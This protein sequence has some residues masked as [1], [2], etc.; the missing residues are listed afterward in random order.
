MKKITTITFILLAQFFAC[1]W[2]FREDK[3]RP[4]NKP[5]AGDRVLADCEFY[6]NEESA[7]SGYLEETESD[8]SFLRKI[9]IEK[10]SQTIFLLSN[11][12]EIYKIDR[13]GKPLLKIE[14][15]GQG[16]GEMALPFDMKIRHNQL[17]VH[18]QGNNKILIFD[19]NGNWIKDVV[20]H[21]LL[22]QSFEVDPELRLIIPKIDLAKN[23]ELP[24]FVFYNEA[25]QV[26]QEISKNRDLEEDFSTIPI[27]PILTLLPNSNLLLTFKIQGRC[28][29]FAPDGSLLQR[30]SIQGG[31]EWSQSVEFEKEMEKNSKYG[32]SY[33]WRVE[34]VDFDSQGNIYASWGGKFKDKPSIVM[35]YDQTGNF[36]GRLFGNANFPYPPTCFALE[37]D[38][39]IWLHSQEKYTFGRCKIRSE[40]SVGEPTG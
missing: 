19:L 2:E 27:R 13:D 14:S 24:L 37:S 18:D 4:G 6:L 30:F 34:N 23:T 8:L 40:S 10:A 16:P 1:D 12:G 21:D 32:K 29:L 22:V 5:L 28:Y 35:I 9:A 33:P 3:K 36:L 7:L 15:Q 25:G 26:V 31:P 17:Y 38:S 11:F 20:I 39:V